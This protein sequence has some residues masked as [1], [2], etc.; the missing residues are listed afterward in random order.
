MTYPL[1]FFRFQDLCKT[2]VLPGIH[3]PNQAVLKLSGS[4]NNVATLQAYLPS[5]GPGGRTLGSGPRQQIHCR[6][7]QNSD[8]LAYAT[9]GVRQQYRDL[10]ASFPTES[11]QLGTL[12]FI[13][14]DNPMWPRPT[15]IAKAGIAKHRRHTR[16]PPTCWVMP[17]T[18][19]LL[20]HAGVFD[21]KL[22][23]VPLAMQ[24]TPCPCWTLRLDPKTLQAH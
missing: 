23:Y 6:V 10:N 14:K 15:S 11:L 4:P 7:K 3:L 21:I 19:H 1:I 2:A 24:G 18:T 12:N 5:P 9:W 8:G 22:C 13:T 17:K 16:G 20:L